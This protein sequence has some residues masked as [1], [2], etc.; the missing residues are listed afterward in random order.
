[1]SEYLPASHSM[2]VSAE[3]APTVV[4][5]VP[6][7]HDT[8]SV[9]VSLP[10]VSRYVPAAQSRQVAVL[11]KSTA[12][13]PQAQSLKYFEEYSSHIDTSVPYTQ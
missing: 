13:E 8:Q 10:P 4:E 3:E 12:D 5:Y 2:H 11:S 9:S 1:M 7:A 6:L